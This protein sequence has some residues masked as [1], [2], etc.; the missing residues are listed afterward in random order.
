MFRIDVAA[1]RERFDLLVVRQDLGVQN[2]RLRSIAVDDAQEPIQVDLI[3]ELP[4]ITRRAIG[5]A[6]RDGR[7]ETGA[8]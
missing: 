2:L 8:G 5:P 6:D 4:Q 3:L 1:D 7:R